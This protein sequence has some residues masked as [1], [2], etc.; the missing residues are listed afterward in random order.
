ME[1][2]RVGTPLDTTAANP[3]MAA[4]GSELTYGRIN[5]DTTQPVC[6]YIPVRRFG[7]RES[8]SNNLATVARTAETDPFIHT[9]CLGEVYDAVLD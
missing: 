2:W 9:T 7:R 6:T 5:C 3:E 8:K 4:A 1:Q